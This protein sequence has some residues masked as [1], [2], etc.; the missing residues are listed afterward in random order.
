TA[1][2]QFTKGTLKLTNLSA[3]GPAGTITGQAELNLQTKQFN[4]SIQSSSIDLSKI[5]A[6]SSLAGLLG[7]NLTIQSTGAGTFNQPELVATATLNQ[8]TLKGLNLPAGSPPPT[9]YIAI[10][11]GQLI[12]RGSVADLVTIE[13]NGSVATDGT[14]SG[15]VQIKVPDLAKLAAISPN[16]ATIPIAGGLMANLELGGKMSSLET[17]RMDATFPQFNVRVSE[18]EFQPVRPLHIALRSG[19]VFFDDFNLVLVGTAST[20][21]IT[22]SA[23][24]VGTKRLNLDIHGLLEAALLALFMKGV[25][26]DGHIILAA[27]IHGTASAPT[28]T[29]TAE[30]EQAQVRFGGFPQLIDHITGRLVFRGD[31]VDVENLRAN[32][33]GGT[34]AAGGTITL[35]GIVPQRV[36]ITLQGTDVAIRYFEGVSVEGNFTL[37]LAGD[38]TR[39]T[40]T[41]DVAVARGL[42]YK[43]ID[44][45][46]M[47]LGVILSRR[48]VTP[49]AAAAWQDKVSLHVHLTAQDTL[50]VRNNIADLTG[51][52]DIDVVG[53]LANPVILGNVTLDEGGRVRFQNI[54]Y[55]LTSGTINF[56]NPFRIDP[57]FDITLEARVTGGISDVEAGPIDVT[58]NITGTIDRITP[59]ITSDPP[60]SD[61][62]LFS[63]LGLG[64]VTARTGATAAD[65]AG[66]A[67]RS[68]LY[69]SAARLLAARVLPFVDA[70]SYDPGLLDTSGD[71]G[72]KVSFE[73]RL[74]NDFTIFVV[75]NTLD[76]KKRLVVEWQVNPEWVV[77]FTRDEMVSEYRAEARYRRRYEGHWTWGS[78]GRTPQASFASLVETPIAPPP[79]PS[80]EP[81]APPA[82]SPVVEQINF[83]ADSNFDTTL[84]RNYTT[85]KIG[86]PLSLREV[87][88]S[89]KSLFSTGDFR[90]I[91]VTDVPS[92]NG[93]A[94]TFAL[95]VNYR[96][97][98]I[99]FEGLGTSDRDRAARELNFRLGDVVSLNAIDRSAVAIQA[100][101]DR[102]GYLEAT[103]D[104]ET[105]F[106]RAQ[107]RATVT[108]HVTRGVRATVGQVTLEGNQAPF[109]ADQLIK[110][111][112]RGPGKPFDLAEARL[113]ADHMRTFLVRQDYRKADIRFLNYTYDATTKKVTLHYRA[114]TGP[115]VKVEVA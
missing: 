108:F 24:L 9:I 31:R 109:T 62:T 107:S 10:R 46:N 13:G 5:T 110:Q 7:G 41:G 96:V 94:L 44:L 25:R 8:A 86:Q 49:V 20:F 99:R 54:D 75:Y 23:E 29:G 22:G 45:G 51:S 114:N 65:T 87:Q 66:L 26:A 81:V 77:Q 11:N 21:G 2:V 69:Q 63:L 70:F 61:I 74:S 78:R 27:G 68:L 85:Q 88:D 67:G 59:T 6:L 84:L 37:Q 14:L 80:N 33:G 18:H 58:V 38:T 28:V 60:A 35:A 19:Q 82:G 55:T 64:G 83:T 95:F 36:R 112:R 43:D 101:L 115:I 102:S 90:D 57:Y 79:A 76:H 16:T 92:G 100:F 111:M 12:V 4:Y 3:Q 30:F 113:D 15:S 106:N 103:V 17:I 104:P 97:G 73:K 42:Y 32:V 71:P 40:L 50:A 89:I 105:V 93:V 53:T 52:G 1:N 56:Q 72:P 47:I 91:R 34:V 98:E 48:G 39:M